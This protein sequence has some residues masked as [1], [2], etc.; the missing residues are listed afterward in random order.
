MDE[1]DDRNPLD[2]DLTLHD[3]RSPLVSDEPAILEEV[4]IEEV[5]IDGMCGV[6]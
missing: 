2:E 3:Q 6:Y 4:K 5:G 1:R